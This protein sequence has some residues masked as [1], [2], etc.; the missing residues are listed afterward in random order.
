MVTKFGWT[1]GE[2]PN[3]SVG[4]IAGVMNTAKNV[5]GL[6][7]HPERALYDWMGGEDGR[8]IFEGRW[9]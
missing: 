4:D 7:P 9:P 8:Q 2:N 3:G 1:Y 6:M 5:A